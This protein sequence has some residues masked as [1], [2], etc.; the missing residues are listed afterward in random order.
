MFAIIQNGGKQYL[1]KPG[2]ELKLEKQA[3]DKSGNLT[4]GEV[5]AVQTANELKLGTPLVEGASVTAKVLEQ[6]RHPKITVVKFKSK[7]N[8]RKSKSH[9]QPYTAVK[10]G[11][12][13]IG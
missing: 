1:V 10:I 2:D 3:A 8:Q 13:K 12:I 11:E 6:G 9:R 5:L 7:T 4:F